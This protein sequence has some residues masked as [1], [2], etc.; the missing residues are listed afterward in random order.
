[1]NLDASSLDIQAND[2]QG[3]IMTREVHWPAESWHTRVLSNTHKIVHLYKLY[4]I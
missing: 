3:L 2:H 4:W 1:M